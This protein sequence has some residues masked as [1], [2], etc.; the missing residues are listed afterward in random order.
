LSPRTASRSVKRNTL[1]SVPRAVSEIIMKLLAKTVGRY[2]TA[3]GVASDLRRCLHQWET[4]RLI[5]EFPLGEHDVPDRLLIPEKLYG[6]AREIEVLLATFHRLVLFLDD[7]QWLDAATLDLLEDLLTR[8]FRDNANVS[9]KEG[10]RRGPG[11]TQGRWQVQQELRSDLVSPPPHSTQK[12]RPSK[13]ISVSSKRCNCAPPVQ[14][15][16]CWQ[17]TDSR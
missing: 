14:P 1:K 16:S 4:Q 3:E 8:A 10:D 6:R 5:A 12:S 7:L 2:Q 11:R 13:S 15:G 9:G 17:T